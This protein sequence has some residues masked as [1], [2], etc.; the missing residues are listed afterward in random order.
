[1]ASYRSQYRASRSGYEGNYRDVAV[2]TQGLPSI[3]GLKLDLDANAGITLT[4][5]KVS[6]WADQSGQGNDY[7]QGTAG[8]RPVVTTSVFGALPGVTGTATTGLA[9][10]TSF[11]TTGSP[12]TIFAVVKGGGSAGASG[13]AI[14]SFKTQVASNFS[15]LQYLWDLS[16]NIYCYGQGTVA[17]TIAGVTVFNTAHIYM[18]TATVGS[19][20]VI[21]V[22]GAAQ[23]VSGGNTVASDSG[24]DGS[25][26]MNVSALSQG[27]IGDIGRVLVYDSVLSAANIALVKAYLSATY[28]VSVS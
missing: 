7:T 18:C 24:T 27:F 5:G 14:I 12:R 8:N 9:R 25:A 1:M 6:T 15:Y 20:P 2:S 13:G 19:L 28:G 22:D 16:P 11:L 21:Q 17:D 10:A 26:V 4:S 3:S 23:T